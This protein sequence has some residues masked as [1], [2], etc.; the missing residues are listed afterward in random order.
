MPG[1]W[2]FGAERYDVGGFI[3]GKSEFY[4]GE[5][6]SRMGFGKINADDYAA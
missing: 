1:R 4:D 5:K 3:H 2:V 6:V